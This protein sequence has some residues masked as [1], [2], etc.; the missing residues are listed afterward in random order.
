MLVFHLLRNPAAVTGY[1]DALSGVLNKEGHMKKRLSVVVVTLALMGGGGIAGAVP[2]HTGDCGWYPSG[3]NHDPLTGTVTTAVL[4]RLNPGFG[5]RSKDVPESSQVSDF[6][7]DIDAL[8]A[9][10]GGRAAFTDRRSGAVYGGHGA[11]ATDNGL[12]GTFVDTPL[13]AA[14]LT[15]INAHQHSRIAF[16]S[17]MTTSG[18]GA[19][20]GYLFGS[21]GSGNPA[22]GRTP[23][24]LTT[25]QPVP[26]PGT[27]I[28][29][30]TG[31]VSLLGY[32]WR[33][34]QQ[35]TT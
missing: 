30:T 31:L 6:T 27:W 1:H 28:L 2:I 20:D 33:K 4:H 32:G 15:G 23:L 18:T 17:S 10:T 12:F 29:M 34:R 3:G 5:F 35:Q 16:G 14:A 8:V 26:E 13:S 7:R 9:G 22:D 25:S 19:D 24:L 11:D 21:S